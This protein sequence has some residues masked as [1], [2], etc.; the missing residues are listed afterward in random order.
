M[1]TKSAFSKFL[2]II[3]QYMMQGDSAY[4]II[5]ASPEE[6]ELES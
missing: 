1:H 2:G 3:E 5:C 4:R 6:D